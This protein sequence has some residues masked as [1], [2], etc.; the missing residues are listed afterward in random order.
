M[1][2]GIKKPNLSRIKNPQI[3]LQLNDFLYL[4]G[5]EGDMGPSFLNSGVP[6]NPLL[7]LTQSLEVTVES[8]G[9][10]QLYVPDL[11]KVFNA[12]ETKHI[13]SEF[14]KV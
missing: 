1:Y 11:N 7:E 8:T 2:L 9:S 12:E 6:N 5:V 3:V 4:K 10:V 14:L 13:Y